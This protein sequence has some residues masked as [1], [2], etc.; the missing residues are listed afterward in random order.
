MSEENVDLA[1]EYIETFNARGLDAGEKLWHSEIELHEPPD[2]PDAD[3]Y[4][5]KAAFRRQ[6][7]SYLGLGWDGQFR[8]PEFI[9]GGDEVV[10]V[11]QGRGRSPQGV[12]MVAT[13]AQVFL[14]EDGKVRRIRQFLTRAE[15]LEAAGLSE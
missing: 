10:V 14:F 3:R 5:G 6:V 13:V 15:A 12:P 11:W 4:K 7:E 9:A 8:S 1:R 2:L